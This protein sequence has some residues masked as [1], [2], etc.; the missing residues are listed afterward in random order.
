M[1]TPVIRVGDEH[2]PYL[3]VSSTKQ[4]VHSGMTAGCLLRVKDKPDCEKNFSTIVLIC[5]FGG[6]GDENRNKHTHTTK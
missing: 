3:R 2:A 5:N 6:F 4:K 1:K